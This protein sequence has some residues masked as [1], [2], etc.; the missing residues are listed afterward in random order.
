MKRQVVKSYSILDDAL[1]E[2]VLTFS[3]GILH[4]ARNGLVDKT[5]VEDK[6]ELPRNWPA[7]ATVTIVCYK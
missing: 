3:V 6:S 5:V 2:H 4:V 1:E 7:L